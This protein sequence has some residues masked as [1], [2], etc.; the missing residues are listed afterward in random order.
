MST[1]ARYVALGD[2]STEGL[3]DPDGT[4]GYRGWADR[5]A[6]RIA[7]AQ[8]GLHY[9][10]L[11]VRGLRTRQILERQLPV[12]RAMRPDLV[13]LFAGTNDVVARRFDAGRVRQDLETMQCA[14]IA[15]GATVIGF[16]LPDLTR[17]LPLGK[18]LAPRIRALNEAVRAAAASSGALMVDFARHPVASD[19]RLWSDDRFHA[20]PL[21][22]H[23]IAG[24]LA[25]ALGVQG[26]DDGWTR[27]FEGPVRTR[28]AGIGWV[29]RHFVPWVW[30]H[31][32]GRSSGDGRVP[33]RPALL[34][35][36]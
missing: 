24:A 36:S 7:A 20:N 5:L 15:G 35:V 22:H 30:R 23:L 17:V 31:A 4:G 13:S 19:L 6:E 25:H 10:N 2:S 9:A 11:G 29:A 34:P 18:V 27:P 16:T 28:P 33:K 1:F 14:L 21:G 3:D 12:A 32:R 8:G 26:A